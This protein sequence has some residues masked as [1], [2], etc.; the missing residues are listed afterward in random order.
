VRSGR[1]LIPTCDARRKDTLIPTR[2]HF[3]EV[4][5]RTIATASC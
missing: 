4:L 1:L 2:R 5:L 3:Q